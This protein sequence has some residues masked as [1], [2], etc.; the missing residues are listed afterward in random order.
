[1]ERTALA[2]GLTTGTGFSQEYGAL[3]PTGSVQ[4]AF[5]DISWLLL[6]YGCRITRPAIYYLSPFAE[7]AN[8]HS[9]TYGNPDLDP[10]LT[11]TYEASYHPMR[12]GAQLGLT[13]SGAPYG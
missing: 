10:E 4:Y 3:L 9:I 7:Y 11:D 13:G 1:M 6:A 5:T 8:Q 2:A 12:R